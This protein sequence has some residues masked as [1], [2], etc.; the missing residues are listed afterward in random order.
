MENPHKSK[1]VNKSV[2]LT[3]K[4]RDYW[5]PFFHLYKAYQTF[6]IKIYEIYECKYWR[7]TI[8]NDTKKKLTPNCSVFSF[9]SFLKKMRKGLCN[10]VKLVFFLLNHQDRGRFCQIN[11]LRGSTI[12]EEHLFFGFNDF[13]FWHQIPP[14][15]GITQI[16]MIK[17]HWYYFYCLSPKAEGQILPK[18]ERTWFFRRE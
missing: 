7:S 14:E 6:E 3:L 2:Y 10:T 15:R 11:K 4:E 12:L 17:Y 1:Y 13:Y 18:P 8:K 9:F 16:T 5:D